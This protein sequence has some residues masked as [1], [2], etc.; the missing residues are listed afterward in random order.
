MALTGDIMQNYKDLQ[1]STGERFA[2][3]AA[4]FLDP[5][6]MQGLDEQGQKGNRELAKWL[7]NQVDD[8]DAVARHQ[9]PEQDKEAA[10]EQRKAEGTGRTSTPQGRSAPAGRQQ[11]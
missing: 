6:V 7:N 5:H 2:H 11:V 1:Q 8:E 10:A 4:R 3:M 9:A